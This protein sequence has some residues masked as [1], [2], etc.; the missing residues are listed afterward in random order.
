[1][2]LH[3]PKYMFLTVQLSF[4]DYHHPSHFVYNSLFIHTKSE[5][6]IIKKIYYFKI[7]IWM[8]LNLSYLLDAETRVK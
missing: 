2:Q 6:V 8:I 4:F 5:S 3:P 1:M 7:V